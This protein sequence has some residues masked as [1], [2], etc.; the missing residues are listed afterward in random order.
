VNE[1]QDT[2]GER[3][4]TTTAGRGDAATAID[5]VLMSHD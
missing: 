2:V 3:S 5:S 4:F 1:H